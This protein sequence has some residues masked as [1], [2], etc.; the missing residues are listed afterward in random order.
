MSE[1]RII[2]FV[3]QGHENAISRT[4]LRLILGLTDRDMREQ[5]ALSEEP[6]YNSGEGYFRYLDLSDMP[7]MKT[8]LKAELHRIQALQSKVEKVRKQINMI[9]KG[10]LWQQDEC[11]QNQ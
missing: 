2:D 4:D 1:L 9:E 5:I 8:Y 10:E 11:S 6:I 3:P 7:Y